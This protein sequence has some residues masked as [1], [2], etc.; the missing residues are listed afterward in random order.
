MDR[1]TIIFR[2]IP[3]AQRMDRSIPRRPSSIFPSSR[4]GQLVGHSTGLQYHPRPT[5]PR[6][7]LARVLHGGRPRRVDHQYCTPHPNVTPD[8]DPS[9]SQTPLDSHY[10]RDPSFR[11]GIIDL[12][13]LCATP[14][15]QST[16]ISARKAS[17]CPK[18][19]RPMRG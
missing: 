3:H 4:K 11:P 7:W 16:R 19:H 10:Q 9:I 1:S 6:N 15:V 18:A 17:L 13:P 8:A 2:H 5:V 14:R 12:S